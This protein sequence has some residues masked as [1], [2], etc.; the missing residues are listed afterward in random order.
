MTF[1]LICV[2]N[3]TSDNLNPRMHARAYVRAGRT[4]VCRSQVHTGLHVFIYVYINMY[5][6]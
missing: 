6:M 4:R 1:C 5:V 2:Y 3:K